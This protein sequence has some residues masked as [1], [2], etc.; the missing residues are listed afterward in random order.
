MA[1]ALGFLGITISNR[2]ASRFEAP[3]GIRGPRGRAPIGS[4][5]RFCYTKA[6]GIGCEYF[7]RRASVP[8]GGNTGERWQHLPRKTMAGRFP[9]LGA[10]GLQL[11]S[12]GTTRPS[13]LYWRRG[14]W[15][16]CGGA[17]AVKMR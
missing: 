3:M 8:A 14:Q 1:G 17:G 9:I 2:G 15:P 12:A 6:V 10:S 5:A 7:P 13:R 4:S 16:L 11:W